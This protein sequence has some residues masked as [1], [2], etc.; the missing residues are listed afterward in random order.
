MFFLQDKEKFDR[1]FDAQENEVR[2]I[3]R[4]SLLEVVKKSRLVFEWI[5]SPPAKFDKEF[6]DELHVPLD[7]T[8]NIYTELGNQS[9]E[10]AQRKHGYS[11]LL[12][13]LQKIWL[14]IRTK[15]IWPFQN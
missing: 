1:K 13:L 2:N 11:A 15:K 5:S 10:I 9:G 7:G 14:F 3:Y 6:Y 4:I 12:Q 8:S